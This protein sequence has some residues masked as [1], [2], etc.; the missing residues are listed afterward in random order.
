MHH[1]QCVVCSVECVTLKRCALM[2]LGKE[3]RARFGTLIGQSRE[4]G[5][6]GQT[7]KKILARGFSTPNP[8]IPSHKHFVLHASPSLST[9]HSP[10]H[11]HSSLSSPWLPP[12]RQA[13]L[14]STP[15]SRISSQPTPRSRKDLLSTRDSPLPEPSA[16]PSPTAH[17]HRLMCTSSAPFDCLMRAQWLGLLFPSYLV[18][19]C[20]PS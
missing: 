8:S 2:W 7:A 4:S 19:S 14:S 3:L 6:A 1:K 10:L 11:S 15:S 13:R 18:K 20:D 9:L 5:K 12:H 17:S 16:A